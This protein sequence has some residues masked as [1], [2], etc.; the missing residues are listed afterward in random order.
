MNSQ[1]ESTT[2]ALYEEMIME[3]PSRRI[4]RRGLQVSCA[5]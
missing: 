4:S 5:R 3:R 2:T 1:D